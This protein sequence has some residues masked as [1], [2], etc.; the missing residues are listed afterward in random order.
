MTHDIRRRVQASAVCLLAALS[1]SA[2]AQSEGSYPTKPIR[3]VVGFSAGGISDLLARALG[4]RLAASV[5]QQVVVDN[6]PG[7][8]TTIA[9]ALVAKSPPDGYTLFMQD[10]TT[11]AINATLY[12]KL[13]YDSVKDFTPVSLVAATPVVVLVHPS[14]PVKSIKELIALA[15]A[16][17]GNITYASAGN[18]TILHLSGEMLASTAGISLL[19]VPYKGGADAVQAVIRGEAAMAFTALPTALPQVKAGRMR[20][21]AVTTPKRV[22][23]IAA[24]VTVAEAGFPELELVLYSGVLGPAGL[25]KDVLARLNAELSTAVRSSEMKPIYDSI[26]AQPL[27]GTPAEFTRFLTSEISR[28][29]KVVQHARVRI[30]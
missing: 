1:A 18:G 2:W 15:K 29:G 4:A 7:A 23:P 19:H 10:M 13:P 28:L 24:V 14:L 11:H 20:A 22:D 25:P 6:R 3:L 8:G 12:Q 9:S 26:G 27:T 21:I 16:K 5:R 17:P 30:D